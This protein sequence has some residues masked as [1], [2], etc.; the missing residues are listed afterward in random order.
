VDRAVLIH[1]L[2]VEL[3]NVPVKLLV[4]SQMES[5]LKRIMTRLTRQMFKLH[6]IDQ[7]DVGA[8]VKRILVKGFEDIVVAHSDMIEAKPWPTE[9]E[10]DSL[11]T[12]AGHLIVYATTVLK[13][14]GDGR[15]PPEG[16]LRQVMAQEAS[17]SVLALNSVDSLYLHILEAATRD[18]AGNTDN[19]L[20]HRLRNLVGVLCVAKRP[21]TV[22]LLVSLIDV[23]IFEAQ[24]N[25]GALSSVLLCS[26]DDDRDVGARM[27]RISHQSFQDFVT[28][29][30]DDSWFFVDST[31]HYAAVAI[32]CL[33][34]LNGALRQDICGIQNY[35]TANADM[36]DPIL[37]IRLQ[38]NV[39]DIVNYACV[40]WPAH[41]PLGG[42]PTPA[43]I[44]QLDIFAQSH[45]LHWIELLSLLDQL[46]HAIM[47]LPI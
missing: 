33:K 44:K 28:G 11:V 47:S 16:R 26:E 34:V 21:L 31:E 7:A 5:V 19:S 25:I 29:R 30:C 9:V 37:A 8:D 23:S 4:T 14:V 32:H 13:Y 43:L 45:L 20:Y 22:A 46:P 15:Y 35:T 18:S 42:A 38:N 10:L 41:V 24:L 17:S 40:F 3:T 36:H 39:L 27:V 1:D 6:E 2:A 12:W